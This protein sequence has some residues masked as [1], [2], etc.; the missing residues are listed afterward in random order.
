MLVIIWI[1]LPH[2]IPQKVIMKAAGALA[3][4]AAIKRETTGA[5]ANPRSSLERETA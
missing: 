1:P 3:T 4:I 2:P 5:G